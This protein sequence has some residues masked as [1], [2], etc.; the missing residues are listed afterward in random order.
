MKV[1]K[2]RRG[3]DGIE[4]TVFDTDTNEETPLN[5]IIK[6]SPTGFEWGYGG[7]GPADLALSILTDAAGY[8]TAQNFYQNFKW[9]FVA[10]FPYKEWQLTEE[11]IRKFLKEKGA[12]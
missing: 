11:E 4:V 10:N 7:S 1:Y 2:G 6:H 8:K 12:L 9:E 3:Y 5:H